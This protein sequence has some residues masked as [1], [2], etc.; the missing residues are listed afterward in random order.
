MSKPWSFTVTCPYCGGPLEHLADGATTT[1]HTRALATCTECD[2]TIILHVEIVAT[3][4]NHQARKPITNHGTEAG[5]QAHRR[6]RT[7]P[8]GDCLTAHNA[9]TAQ[10]KRNG[11]DTD[12]D[13]PPLAKVDC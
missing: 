3:V 9:Y 10:R 4:D 12:A 11:I 5:Y 2:A 7:T 1:W 8:C 6:R 13:R